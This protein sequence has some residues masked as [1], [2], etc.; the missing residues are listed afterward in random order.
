M[1][2]SFVVGLALAALILLVEHWIPWKRRPGSLARY[3]MGS[4]AILAGVALWLGQRGEWLTLLMLFCFYL[5]GGAATASA[6]LYDH[7]SNTEQRLRTHERDS[8]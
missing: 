8:E 3:V 5:V 2:F 4:A 6:H 7:L 1:T